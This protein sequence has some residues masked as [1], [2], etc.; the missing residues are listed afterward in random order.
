MGKETWRRITRFPG[1]E[2]S[3]FGRIRNANGKIMKLSSNGNGYLKFRRRVNGKYISDYV[4][5]IVAEA[6]IPNPNGK[7]CVNHIDCNPENNSAVNLEW[8]TKA[9]NTAHMI[10]LGRNKRTEEWIEHLYDGFENAGIL[11]P[12]LGQNIST[13]NVIVF[14]YLNQVRALG[15]Q[16]SS[17][18]MCCKNQMK[19]HKGYTWRYV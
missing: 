15:F 1:Y 4:H 10:K 19:Q 11:R 17:V 7:P 8:C 3:D 2:V 13:G 16:P 18:C 6:F 9:E 12:V 5:R 14:S